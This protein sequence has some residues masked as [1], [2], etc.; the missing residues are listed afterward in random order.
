MVDGY[1]VGLLWSFVL[2][3]SILL[4][5]VSSQHKSA[6]LLVWLAKIFT[7]LGVMLVFEIHY[8]GAVDGVVYY[9]KSTTDSFSWEN[10]MFGE[11]TTN[12]IN[13]AILYQMIFP[14]SYHAMKITVSMVGMIGVYIFYRASILYL[15]QDDIRIFYALALYPT[16][17]FWTSLI[18]KDSFVLLGVAFYAYGVVGWHKF[19]Q[20]RY[21]LWGAFGVW[22]A[23]FMRLWYGPILVAPLIIFF[24]NKKSGWMSKII[25]AVIVVFS[26]FILSSIFSERLKIENTEDLMKQTNNISQS[27]VQGGS[28]Q[29]VETVS[30]P[31]QMIALMPFGLFTA[32]FRPLPGEILNAF[33]LIAGFENLFLLW[34][35]YSAM[36]NIQIKDITEPVILW[37]IALIIIW[38]SIYGFASM[39]NLGSAVRY[40]VPILPLLVALLLYLYFK[41][42]YQISKVKFKGSKFLKNK[43]LIFKIKV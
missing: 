19:G 12:I 15:E 8:E 9:Y 43:K 42:S 28:G 18:A 7:S 38:G 3:A 5:P 30:S 2:G 21:L 34:L 10:F 22:F 16:I 33:G 1:F 6:L 41:S 17:L 20:T 35:L 13:F 23:S 39:G 25:F 26:L 29:A 4:W 36:K 37:A 31:A 24:L 14:D 40:R 32:L 27:F 11:G